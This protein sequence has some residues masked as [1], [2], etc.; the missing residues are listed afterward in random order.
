MEITCNT[1]LGLI[2]GCYAYRTSCLH[3]LCPSCA[4]K[5]FSTGRS[6]PSCSAILNQSELS[7]INIGI[8]GLNF[9]ELSFQYVFKSCDWKSLWDKM[10][11]CWQTHNYISHFLIKQLS[12]QVE[13]FKEERQAMVGDIQRQFE[14]VVSVSNS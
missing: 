10:E 1:C 4:T 14:T 13:R 6:C 12:F 9:L 5:A 8:S 3:F 7:E 11:E 2:T